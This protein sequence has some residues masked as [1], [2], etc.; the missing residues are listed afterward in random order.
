[1]VRI[2]RFGRGLPVL[3]LSVAMLGAFAQQATG[4]GAGGPKGAQ[5][6][7]YPSLSHDGRYLAFSTGSPLA[8]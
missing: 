2:R 1:M 6:N 8:S 4:L 7:Q 3:V 5:S